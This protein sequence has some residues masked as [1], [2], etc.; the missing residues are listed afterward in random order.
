MLLVWDPASRKAVE[1]QFSGY[2]RH[3]DCFPPGAEF[4][5]HE[6]PDVLCFQETKA[7][8]EEL[9]EEILLQEYPHRYWFAAEK[10][11]YSGVGE[12]CVSPNCDSQNLMARNDVQSQASQ[13][14]VRVRQQGRSGARQGG[15]ADNGGVRLL[16]PAGRLRAQRRQEARH[17]GQEDEVGWDVQVSHQLAGWERELLVSRKYVKKL[18]KKKPVIICGDMNVAHTEMDLKNPKSNKRNAGFTQEERDGFS[19][20]LGA[21][22]V[23]SF[24]LCVFVLS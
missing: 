7:T 21:G 14:Q 4:P 11:G 22:F 6:M 24:R 2:T 10:D 5:L 3:H 23:D 19:E 16:L 1:I 9:P 13:C 18:D 12:C 8:E 15:A 20:L 17:H